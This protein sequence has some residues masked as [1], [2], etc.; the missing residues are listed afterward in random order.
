MINTSVRPT[1]RIE[2]MMHTYG[3]M[4]FRLCLIT[5]GN[6]SDAEDVVQETLIKYL[7]KAP[8][9][10]DAEHEKAWLITVA[11]NKC[12]DVLRFKNRHPVVEVDEINEFT[13]DTSDSGILDALMTLPDK[14][15]TVLVLYYVEEYSTEDIA[16][17][18]GKTA[19]AVKMRLQ[20]GR[21]LLREIYRKEYM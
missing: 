20:K 21:R 3:N 2:A 5:L 12:K 17:M 16:R 13:K 4:L 11:T 6:A 18:I 9:F 7:Q 14:F 19:S 1:D 15:R 8:E 10:K